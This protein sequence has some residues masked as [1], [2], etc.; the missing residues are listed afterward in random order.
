M[1]VK[2]GTYPGCETPGETDSPCSE[3]NL[4]KTCA[5]KS[6]GKYLCTSTETSS[7]SDQDSTESVKK[8]L[9]GIGGCPSF[10]HIH[11]E[12]ASSSSLAG[13]YVCFHKLEHS[14]KDLCVTL[15]TRQGA[16]I[17]IDYYCRP[18]QS[19]SNNYE[20]YLLPFF[21]P[22]ENIISCDLKSSGTWQDEKKPPVLFGIQFLDGKISGLRPP[23]RPIFDD[24]DEATKQSPSKSKKVS[25]GFS[26]RAIFE[27]LSRNLVILREERQLIGSRL[28]EQLSDKQRQMETLV[29]SVINHF[30]EQLKSVREELAEKKAELVE[31]RSELSEERKRH[32]SEVQ[33]LYS[34]L[35]RHTS[36][37]ELPSEEG[38]RD[39]T[40]VSIGKRRFGADLPDIP[41]ELEI[42]AAN[43]LQSN[44][45]MEEGD[46]MPTQK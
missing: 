22:V 21:R 30:Q 3:A 31:C 42:S 17:V 2:K 4:L 8:L 11:I 16:K 7:V 19:Y 5:S 24:A 41:V 40:S 13:I 28:Q 12:L 33:M 23:M 14:P 20:W 6:F 1:Y 39:V 29:S 38:E 36:G 9:E 27:F 10:N 26:D 46:S 32:S 37:A 43:V 34:L 15:T 18:P 35:E 44:Q 25:S 45:I